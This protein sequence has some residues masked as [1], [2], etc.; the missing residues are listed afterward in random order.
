[1]PSEALC[2][3]LRQDNA[4]AGRGQ[5]DALTTEEREELRRPRRE[6]KVRLPRL[7]SCWRILW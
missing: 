2:H 4:D 1:M 3:W 7:R 5:A 6:V